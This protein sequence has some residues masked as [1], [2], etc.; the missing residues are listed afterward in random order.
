MATIKQYNKKTGTTYVYESHS[1][2]DKERKQHRSDRKLIGKIDPETGEIVPTKKKKTAAPVDEEAQSREVEK[3]N[4]QLSEYAAV[5]SGQKEQIRQLK[6]ELRRRDQMIQK[7][8]AII[9]E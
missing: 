7:I 9:A 8:R 3:L 2:W 4:Q 5:I 6:D 1:Y